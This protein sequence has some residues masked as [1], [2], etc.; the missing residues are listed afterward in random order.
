M[1]TPAGHDKHVVI[2]SIE[3]FNPYHDQRGRFSTADGAA[4]FTIT[5]R[6]PH[7][8]HWAERAKEREKQR[9]SILGT[10][11][12][13]IESS[14]QA[15][16]YAVQSLGFKA[17]DLSGLDAET[18][19]HIVNTIEVI[20]S[21]YP[22]LKG[23]VDQIVRDRRGNSYAAMETS[24]YVRQ[25]GSP[26]SMKLHIGTH[27]DKGL[28]HVKQSYDHDLQSGFHPKGTNAESIVWHE[29]GHALANLKSAKAAANLYHDA[30]DNY[31][32]ASKYTSDRKKHLTEKEWLR[33]AA[34]SLKVTQKAFKESISR[35]ATKNA[36]ET[37]AE[38]FAEFTT[39]ASPR[40]ECIALMKAAGIT[41]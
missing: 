18:S 15:E 20:Q 24:G 1:I 22:E 9:I 11:E 31:W 35:Y 30:N 7:K 16:L 27:Y 14:K 34:K 29:Y 40:A 28:D 3:K 12:N 41:S 8:Q 6:D 2:E 21:R 23:A 10:A 13:K 5:T 19:S 32:R 36:A 38:A 33:T 17:A 39:S 26:L 37:F 4:S 25:D